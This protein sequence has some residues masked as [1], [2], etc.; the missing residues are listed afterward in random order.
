MSKADEMFE[1]LGYKKHDNHPEHDEPLTRHSWSTQDCRIIEY[2][3]EDFIKGH[4]CLQRF[5]FE[6]LN[7]RIVF[8]GYYDG[9]IIRAIPCSAE[10]IK[11][12]NEKCKE[13][14]WLDE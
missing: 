13:L 7:Q 2:T 8:E 10:E 5:S 9:R 3:S 14:G 11:A 4:H 6:I 12:I 1:K